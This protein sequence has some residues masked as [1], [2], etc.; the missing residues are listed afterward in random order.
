MP[1]D[2]VTVLLPVPDSPGSTPTTA[3]LTL[4]T[5]HPEF[6]AKERYIVHARLAGTYPRAIGLP[7][8]ILEVTG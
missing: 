1:P 3:I 5:C 2:R 8:G 7:S 4:T 6:S